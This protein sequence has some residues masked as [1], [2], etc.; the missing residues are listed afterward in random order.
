MSFIWALSKT[1]TYGILGSNDTINKW[2]STFLKQLFTK[3]SQNMA[4]MS[5]PFASVMDNASVYVSSQMLSFCKSSKLKFL[6]IPPYSP[7][8]NPLEKLVGAVRTNLFK[9]QDKGWYNYRF[10]FQLRID[11]WIFDRFR[12]PLIRLQRQILPNT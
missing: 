5:R 10:K 1:Q 8:L 7:S 2:W 12:G 4:N 3:R 9:E 11:C 6:T